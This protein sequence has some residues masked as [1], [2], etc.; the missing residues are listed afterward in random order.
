MDP[1][2]GTPHLRIA[3]PSRDLALAE[4]FWSAGVGLSVLYRHAPTERGDGEHALIMLGLPAASWHLELVHDAADP[5]GPTPTPEDLLV[6]YLD[7]PAPD[8]LLDRIEGSGG[9]RVSSHNPYWD[10]WGVTFVDPDGYRLVL[11]T[12]SWSST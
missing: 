6:L 8:G 5:V 10:R 11:S 7:G 1:M 9:T 12:R 3:R 4:R 2:T